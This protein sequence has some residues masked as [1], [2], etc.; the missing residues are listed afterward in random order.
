MQYISTG[1][2]ARICEVGVNTIKRWIK[3]GKLPASTTPGGRWRIPAYQFVPFLKEHGIPV[4]EQLQHIEPCILI[5]DDDPAV[6]HLLTDALDA[7]PFPAEVHCV[8][9][10]YDGLVRVGQLQ[11]QL[12]VLDILMPRING[13]ELIRRLRLSPDADRQM[14]ILA[15]TGIR[16]DE[17]LMRQLRAVGPDA[18]LFKPIELQAFL[19]TVQQLLSGDGPCYEA[20]ANMGG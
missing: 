14:R 10:G 2:A 16:D 9:D 19:R 4:P 17:K 3:Q 15:I 6:C 5:I 18:I 1:D 7:A 12:L 8:R 11:P 13:V 20:G